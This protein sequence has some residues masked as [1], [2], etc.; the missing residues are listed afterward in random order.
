MLIT[1]DYRNLAHYR[2]LVVLGSKGSGSTP[3]GSTGFRRH[4]MAGLHQW[5]IVTAAPLVGTCC[6]PYG[7]LTLDG[8]VWVNG[9]TSFQG[10][11]GD[12]WV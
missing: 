2:L 6:A 8:G 5:G 9:H 1:C 11:W 3:S 7:Q 10:L 12:G 4:N